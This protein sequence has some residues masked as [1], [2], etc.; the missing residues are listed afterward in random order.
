MNI[1]SDVMPIFYPYGGDFLLNEACSFAYDE[2]VDVSVANT[3]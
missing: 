3:E 1:E 2:R